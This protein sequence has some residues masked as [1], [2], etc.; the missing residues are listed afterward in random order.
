M[1]DLKTLT[2]EQIRMCL[3]TV[4]S[5]TFLFIVG[6]ALDSDEPL[7]TVRMADGEHIL[8]DWCRKAED[9]N[10]IVKPTN[11][12]DQAWLDKFGVAGITYGEL[13]SRLLF[14]AEK[15]TYFCASISGITMNHYNVYNFSK[16]EK[17]VDNFFNYA[18][19]EE[20]K[21]GLMKKAGHVLLIHHNPEVYYTLRSNAEK[22][23]VKISYIQMSNWRDAERVIGQAEVSDAKLVIYSAGPAG[24]IIAPQIAEG[25][26]KKVVLD[27]GSA[28]QRWMLD[29]I[30]RP[31]GEL[32][33]V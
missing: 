18:W 21:R 7:S 23:G 32:I 10:A 2:D 25:K 22:I 12:L 20:Y 13:E 33:N 14:A 11:Q 24:K 19:S 26:F 4:S 5:N 9:K 16:R 3:N 8:M 29:G 15:A 30:Q 6:H 17:Y 28:M 1:W 27:V 31:S